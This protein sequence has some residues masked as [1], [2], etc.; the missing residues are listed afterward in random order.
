M[1]GQIVLIAYAVGQEG[2]FIKAFRGSDY[3][4]LPVADGYSADANRYAVAGAVMEEHLDFA[5]PAV[6]DGRD[7]GTSRAAMET[8]AFVALGEDVIVANV[9]ENL[10]APVAGNLLGAVIPK[11]NFS[12]APDEV[13]PSLY[14]V[15]DDAENLWIMQSQHA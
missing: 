8:V 13:D 1:C 15:E 7:D 14:A 12:I 3:G 6:V 10:V 4:A 5:G 2:V 11:Q 9:A